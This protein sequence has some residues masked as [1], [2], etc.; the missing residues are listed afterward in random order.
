MACKDEKAAMLRVA[1]HDF[2]SRSISKHSPNR[3]QMAGRTFVHISMFSY[4]HRKQIL[5]CA[6]SF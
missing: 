5:T 2:R 4:Q 1:D 3:I 6:K